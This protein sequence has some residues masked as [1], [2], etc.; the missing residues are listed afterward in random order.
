MERMAATV[1]AILS[2]GLQWVAAG[3]RVFRG[4]P[5]NTLSLVQPHSAPGRGGIDRRNGATSEES[6]GCWIR[7]AGHH[8][9]GSPGRRCQ[10]RRQGGGNYPSCPAFE[11]L[12]R[13]HC[14]MPWFGRYEPQDV[15]PYP[16]N[17][18][19]E[20]LSMGSSRSSLIC[21]S[22]LPSMHNRLPT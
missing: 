1:E 6:D 13:S 7:R 3:I 5:K 9:I 22:L 20:R 17:P 12:L 14:V 21:R 15:F 8:W 4:S 2:N 18:L 10:K 19:C 11:T 16:K